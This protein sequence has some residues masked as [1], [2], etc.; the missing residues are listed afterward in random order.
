MYADACIA[1]ALLGPALVSDGPD[2]WRMPELD[3]LA[4]R[5]R[6]LEAGDADAGLSELPPLDRRGASIENP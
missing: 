6:E 1:G 5:F 3:Q 4:A 2:P